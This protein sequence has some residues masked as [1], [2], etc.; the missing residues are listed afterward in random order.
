MTTVRLT[1]GWATTV[2]QVVGGYTL[3][4]V[5]R[6]NAAGEWVLTVPLRYLAAARA[7]DSVVVSDRG[8]VI[9]AGW[10]DAVKT[11]GADGAVAVEVSGPDAWG[12]LF[13]PPVWPVAG[14]TNWTTAGYDVQTGAAGTV[15]G[16]FVRDTIGATAGAARAIAGLTV[17]A[18][19]V[20]VSGTWQARLTPL[21]AIVAQVGLEGGVTTL[22]TVGP[23]GA[24]VVTVRAPVNRSASIRWTGRQAS[25]WSVV[26]A[27]AR[28]TA[29]VVAGQGEDVLRMF[30]RADNGTT[31][32]SRVEVFVD[33]R[34]VAAQADLDRLAT[35]ELA[36]RAADVAVTIT[37][38]TAAAAAW[39][40]GRDYELGDTVAAQLDD[41]AVVAVVTA[42]SIT[43]DEAG[44]WFR[45][46]L[47][48]VP[49]DAL[50]KLD[51]A[52][53]DNGARLSA[54]ESAT[55][56]VGAWQAPALTGQWRAYPS[57]FQ[58]PRY[59]LERG[60][61]RCEGLLQNIGGVAASQPIFT[62][63]V[64]LRPALEQMTTQY[65]SYASATGAA[66]ATRVDVTAAGVVVYL[67]N[68]SLPDANWLTVNFYVPL[69]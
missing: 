37:P 28:A 65:V 9:F 18:P 33:A 41:L 16:A 22:A 69:S 64:G 19:A 59:R 58:V 67:G 40:W 8:A 50:A 2:A 15:V 43:V 6:N 42:V 20:G 14:S 36:A 68:V 60:C 3:K 44:T 55:A 23:T 4:A 63:P 27:P 11:T 30:A 5:V 52:V 61:V 66:G 54:L 13:A 49:R 25:S 26:R 53:A 7:A 35:A 34:N 57:G 51:G 56:T 10:V 62:L 12:R 31:G 24:P 21:A 29:V 47:G 45:P 46:V 38:T 17:V 39:R 32:L 48:A 1:T